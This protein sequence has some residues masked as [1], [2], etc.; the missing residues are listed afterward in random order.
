MS[1][2]QISESRNAETH[3]S[4]YFM[5]ICDGFLSLWLVLSHSK[6]RTKMCS[7]ISFD[8]IYVHV[9]DRNEQRGLSRMVENIPKMEKKN[10]T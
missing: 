10:P 6:I 2:Q 1:Y 7:L 9:I 8:G 5:L 4:G 3:V